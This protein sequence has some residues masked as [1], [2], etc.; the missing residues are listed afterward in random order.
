MAAV[1]F[2]LQCADGALF[3]GSARANDLDAVLAHHAEGRDRNAFTF[4]RRPVTLVWL[5]RYA[6]IMQAWAA[7]RRLKSW[8]EADRRSLVGPSLPDA[9]PHRW[10]GGLSNGGHRWRLAG[11]RRP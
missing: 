3:I 2:M 11:P 8:S 1:V 5:D 9:N 4:P 10:R 7:E 6:D